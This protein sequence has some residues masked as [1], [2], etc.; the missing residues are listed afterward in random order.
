[1]SGGT[2]TW[3]TLAGG[4]I[5]SLGGISSSVQF[6]SVGNTGTDFNIASS[7]S[8]HTFNIPYA[9]STATGLLRSI[10]WT[11]FNNKVG[12]IS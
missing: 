2:P 8:T 11:T 6:F 3:I 5:S 10:D 1:M 12:V 4:G 7:G 9:S